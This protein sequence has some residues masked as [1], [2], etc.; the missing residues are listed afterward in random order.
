MWSS[1][2]KLIDVPFQHKRYICVD[3]PGVVKNVDKALQSIGGTENI[4]KV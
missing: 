4:T 2:D 1:G 3:Y